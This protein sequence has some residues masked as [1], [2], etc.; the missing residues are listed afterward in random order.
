VVEGEAAWSA[1]AALRG[2]GFRTGLPA[3]AASLCRESQALVATDLVGPELDAG[4]AGMYLQ[5]VAESLRD[6]RLVL[7]LPVERRDDFR[8]AL[9]RELAAVFEGTTE[10]R[11]ALS[12]VAKGWQE[13]TAEIGA[14]RLRDT[15]RIA[16]GLFPTVRGKRPADRPTGRDR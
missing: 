14:E 16:L 6:R 3:G 4:E 12:A 8:A 9:A 11:A 5:A 10:P 7:E 2:E 15:Y 13:I 1:F